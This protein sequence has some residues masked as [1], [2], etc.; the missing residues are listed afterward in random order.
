MDK[1]HFII[2][3]VVYIIAGFFIDSLTGFFIVSLSL[4]AAQG[5]NEALQAIDTKLVKK[6]GSHQGFVDNSRK[7]WKLF[8]VGFFFGS[9][10]YAIVA[11]IVTRLN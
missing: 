7:D 10:L 5:I 11:S 3:V 6:Y 2:P 1:Y 4:W 9:F 8:V